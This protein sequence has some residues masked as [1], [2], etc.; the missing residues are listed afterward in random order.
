MDLIWTGITPK[1]ILPSLGTCS[2]WPCYALFSAITISSRGAVL[3]EYSRVRRME[4]VELWT[5]PISRNMVSSPP[6]AISP[7][8]SFDVHIFV[9]QYHTHVHTQHEIK[10]PAVREFSTVPHHTPY[11]LTHANNKCWSHHPTS[12]TQFHPFGRYSCFYTIS[13]YF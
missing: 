4:R 5:A 1:Q 11:L 8:T 7:K 6:V 9:P 3:E 13:H 2:S 12:T 10:S